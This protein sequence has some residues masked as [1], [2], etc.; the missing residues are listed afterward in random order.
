MLAFGLRAS[1]QQCR[2][3]GVECVERSSVVSPII[4]RQRDA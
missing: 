3:E 1:R 2:D 4:G